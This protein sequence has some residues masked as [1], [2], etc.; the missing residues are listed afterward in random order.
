[1]RKDVNIK[2]IL[3]FC[4]ISSIIFTL[5]NLWWLIIAIPS[6]ITASTNIIQNTV[7]ATLRTSP[8]VNSIANSFRYLGYW[9]WF[10]GM[11]ANHSYVLF[12][13]L[14]NLK[15]TFI[16]YSFFVAI[17][18]FVLAIYFSLLK[19][20][21]K[22]IVIFWL[23]IFIF[24]VFISKGNTSPC[25][26]IFNL[27]WTKFFILKF[28]RDPW[29]KF[30]PL[31]ILSS[32]VLSAIFLNFI[33]KKI[34]YSYIVLTII[35]I[36]HLN[37]FAFHSSIYYSDN[38]GTMR[39]L[40]VNVPKYWKDYSNSMGE[41][42]LEMRNLIYPKSPN[43]SHF[44]E[45]GF[46]AALL[47]VSLASR[48]PI[49]IFPNF[50]NTGNLSD[51]TVE[52]FYYDISE[53]HK[54]FL[55]FFNI[56]Y[57]TQQ[58]DYNWISG[59][60]DTHSP[61]EMEKILNENNVLEKNDQFGKFDSELLN[62]ID[63]GRDK[64]ENDKQYITSELL[65]R[66]AINIYKIKPAYFLPHF[67]TPQNSLISSRPIEDL[68]RILNQDDWETRS[69][70]FFESQN[71]GKEKILSEIQ[72]SKSQAPNKF[73]PPVGGQNSNDQNGSEIAPM[74]YAKSV[75]SE[76]S[77]PQGKPVLEFKKINPTKYRIRVH[78]A[79]GVFPLVFSESFHEGWK[80]YL[81]KNDEVKIPL[82]LPFKKGEDWVN[83]YK[84]LDG[85]EDPKNKSGI[86]SGAG[87]PSHKSGI[88]DGV[89]QALK[90]YKILDGN[91]ED[92]A[93]KDELASYIQNG[94]VTTLGPSDFSKKLEGA[95][96][97]KHMK[98]VDGK[99]V[100]DYVEKYNIDFISKNFQGTIQNDNLPSGNFYET[101]LAGN[102]NDPKNKSGIFSGASFAWNDKVKEISPVNHL[103]ANGYANS[104]VIDTEK[105]CK[106]NPNMCV[107][108]RTSCGISQD[109][110]CIPQDKYDF[111]MVVE[112]WPQRLFYIGLFISGMTLLSCIGY[113]IYNYRRNKIIAKKR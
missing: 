29:A 102:M 21:R 11:D 68:P 75:D 101:W 69:A 72:N 6:M 22:K 37:Y 38:Y 59:Y 73:N 16:I 58:N 19:I 24:S 42:K 100:L 93:N 63:F 78:G 49:I 9:A 12:S 61:K 14:F 7:F 60:S 33:V 89:N 43:G 92:Q 48:H 32:V 84:I 25:G 34:K 35:A 30:T 39:T 67:Y 18:T 36:F 104:W 77:I 65:N 47:F 51:K 76:E 52:D 44:F 15:S 106:D 90:N 110:S 5:L 64:S 27:L 80:S 8:G 20:K 86:F 109:E 26:E 28:F 107:I 70:V 95:R 45:S 82:N 41:K 79:T 85:N 71:T 53:Y 105:L 103:M 97:I 87:D 54:Y 56:G 99:E 113:L 10:S 66:P 13:K 46:S 74:E 94:W 108:R 55:T 23:L 88:S 111:E 2:E 17:L 81:V 3:K 98:W 1:I 40:H 96:E 57:I 50:S 31:I 112:F 62:R 91:S 83:N 4:L